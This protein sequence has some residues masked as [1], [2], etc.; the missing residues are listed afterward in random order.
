MFFQILGA[1]D[2]SCAVSG[3]GQSRGMTTLKVV[4]KELHGCSGVTY[5]YLMKKTP[6][7]WESFNSQKQ[8]AAAILLL[9]C[10]DMGF[11]AFF[12]RVTKASVRSLYILCKLTHQ[13]SCPEFLAASGRYELKVKLACGVENSDFQAPLARLKILAWFEKPCLIYSSG[14]IILHVIDNFI[15]S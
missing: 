9:V 10:N 5:P 4:S 2:F 8:L 1:T 11:F 14:W 15:L 6:L 13:C 7:V 12:P 3:F